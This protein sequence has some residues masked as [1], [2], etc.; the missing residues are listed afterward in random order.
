V[1]TKRVEYKGMT[2]SAGAFEVVELSRFISTLWIA[3]D[4]APE[5]ADSAKL[6]SPPLP[7]E[8]FSDAGEALKSAI[9]FGQSVI[10]GEIP[11]LT[12]DDPKA[13]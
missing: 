6:F 8:L 3:K 12:M 10:D 1:P 11:G 5:A 9:A 4:G 7:P 13:N 2:I